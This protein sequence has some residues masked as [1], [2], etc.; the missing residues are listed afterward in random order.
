MKWNGQ[1]VQTFLEAREYV[2]TV[3]MPLLPVDLDNEI[4]QAA[5]MS[6]FISLVAA[7]LERQFK[8]RILM[9]PGY[10]YLKSVLEEKLVEDLQTWE[11]QLVANGFTHVFYLSS[12]VFWKSVEQRFDG[13]LIW[14]PSIPLE[15]MQESQK[16]S[17]IESQVKQMINLFTQK[18]RA[19]E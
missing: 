7:Q 18:W 10:S 9:L 11:K 13:S 3:V 5:Q 15:T 6:E 8:G 16:I 19:N 12:D 2:D 1:D 4:V 17:A 14:I